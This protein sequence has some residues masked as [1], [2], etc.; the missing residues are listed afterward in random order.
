MTRKTTDRSGFTL[1]ELLM[2]MAISVLLVAGIL[3]IFLVNQNAW[4]I[5][6][7]T[8]D[9]SGRASSAINKIVYG[10]G[11]GES[12]RMAKESEVMY[13]PDPYGS[14]SWEVS[15]KDSAGRCPLNRIQ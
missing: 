12:L 11:T 3:A 8:I 4:A 10:F 13:L 9:S 5:T 7:L 15:Y 6:T 14:D 1:I 2:A